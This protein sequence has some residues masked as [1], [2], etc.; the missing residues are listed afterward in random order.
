MLLLG[1]QIRRLVSGIL[2]V[3][4]LYGSTIEVVVADIHA[5][6][7]FQAVSMSDRLDIVFFCSEKADKA[8]NKISVDNMKVVRIP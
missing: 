7:T 6:A 1:V 5:G 2:L 8:S 4:L 3:C